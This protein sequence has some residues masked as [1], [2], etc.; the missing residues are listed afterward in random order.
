MP[1]F[2]AIAAIALALWAAWWWFIGRN[3]PIVPP[4]NIADDDP[5]MLEAVAKA[6]AS[7]PEM[8]QHFA[9]SPEH[10]RVKVPFLTSSAETELLWAELL[11]IADDDMEVR[12]ITPPVT[13]TGRLERVHRH[14][15]GELRDWV[16]TK[17]AGDYRGGFSMR[18]MFIRGRE[19]WGEL[20]P[21]VK[22]EEA[23]YAKAGG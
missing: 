17:T 15:L 13:H 4:L 12:Y 20:P 23:N 19:A 1:T 10:V 16:F 18:V 14:P 9:E 6:R 22:A 11:A 21:Q 8:R 3:R 7:I 5:L 2:L